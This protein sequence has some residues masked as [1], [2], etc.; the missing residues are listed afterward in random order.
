MAELA[1]RQHGVLSRLQLIEIGFTRRA[2]ANRLK[3]GRLHQ[4]HP[5]VYAVGH[6]K[7]TQQGR[8]M[9][10]VLAAGPS[11]VLSHRS[12]A[13]LWRIRGAEGPTRIEVTAPRSRSS[14]PGIRVFHGA[15]QL[16]EITT[17]GGIP[18]TTVPRTI[19]DLASQL[20]AHGV[21]R[22]MNQAQAQHPTDPLPLGAVVD[23]YPRRK[24]TGTIRTILAARGEAQGATKS[25]LEEVFLTFLAARN[26]PKPDKLNTHIYA[27][28]QLIECDC[29]W[30]RHRLIAELDSRA[31]HTDD[32]AF[33][34]DRQRD[35]SLL[36]EG[37]STI[38]ITWRQ[39]RDKP[40]ELHADLLALLGAVVRR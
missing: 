5:G 12:A 23:R 36:V 10:A 26:L 31:F 38:R 29:I 16:D 6:T 13:A 8:W 15:I 21:E 20:D 18:V 28:T 2:I 22:A 34:R 19:L 33:E 11:A 17:E 39:L 25:D 3:R 14:R 4:L 30:F 27:G 35:R 37:W 9:A 1:G 32:E 7:L 24:G 40:D